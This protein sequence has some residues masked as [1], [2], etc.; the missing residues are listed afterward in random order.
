VTIFDE[1]V[2]D[3]SAIVALVIHEEHTAWARQKLSEQRYFHVLDLSYYEVANAIRYKISR[4]FTQKDALVPWAD[5]RKLM[6]QFFQ[7]SFSETVDEA[8]RIASNLSI[9][10]YDAAFLSLADSSNLR[11]LTLDEKLFKKLEG[12]KYHKLLE[13]PTE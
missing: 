3:S 4:D 6:S 8:F 2:L 10:V 11:F 5:A 1:A 13:S 7:H 9:S 12:T